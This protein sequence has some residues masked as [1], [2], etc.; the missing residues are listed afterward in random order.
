MKTTLRSALTAGALALFTVAPAFAL[1]NPGTPHCVT[2]GGPG[3]RLAKA[4]QQVF[5]P[6]NFNDCDQNTTLCGNDIVSPPDARSR[7]K[8][9]TTPTIPIPPPGSIQVR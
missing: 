5:N 9:L 8:L 6:G 4:K 1:C 3:S 2:D 7:S